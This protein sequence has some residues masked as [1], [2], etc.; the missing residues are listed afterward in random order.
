MFY[1]YIF[2]LILK[3][4]TW[5]VECRDLVLFHVYYM[6]LVGYWIVQYDFR[7]MAFHF[8]LHCFS[9]FY[10]AKQTREKARRSLAFPPVSKPHTYIT[11]M[12]RQCTSIV[13]LLECMPQARRVSGDVHVYR[14]NL[15]LPFSCWF[16]KLFCSSAPIIRNID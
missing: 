14:C 7:A 4:L 11:Y 1:A 5:N 6:M 12:L 9:T 15:F 3:H 16:L 2:F 13:Y 10:R 8:G